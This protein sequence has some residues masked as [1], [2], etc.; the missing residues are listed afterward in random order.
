[1]FF[2]IFEQA[3]PDSRWFDASPGSTHGGEDLIG[4]R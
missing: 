4:A 2:L 3:L 1:M